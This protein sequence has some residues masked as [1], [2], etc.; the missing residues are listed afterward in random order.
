[1]KKRLVTALVAGI[2]AGGSILGLAACGE[3]NNSGKT[4]IKAATGARPAPFILT[5][6]NKDEALQTTKDGV[7]LTGY[8]IA[9]IT[10]V[11]KL[12]ELENYELDLNVSSNTLV[13]AQT[14][15]VDFAINNYGYNDD[16]AQ[17]YYYSY[18]YTKS[19]YQ[20][21]ALNVADSF[22]SV[23]N[24]GLKIYSGAG[25][26]TGN[27][28]ERWNE[29]RTSGQTKITL[30]YTSADMTVQLQEA[31]EGK[32]ALIHDEP[33]MYS[34]SKAYPDLFK[35][36][37][38]TTLSDEEVA[39]NITAYNTSHLLFGKAG[40]HAKEYRDLISGGIKKLYE[41]G[42]LAEFSKKYVGE[43]VNV[44]PSASDYTKYLN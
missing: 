34:Y 3:E 5:T 12:P 6:E 41:N 14:G 38:I 1:M 22:E 31:I 4:V 35:D 36:L 30:D 13:D 43:T 25:S 27:A 24:Q 18:P 21:A 11:F 8:D 39:Q 37:T 23:A 29:K 26:H 9:V 16:R 28:I 7:Y 32:V 17:S 15:T 2:L 42:K 19:R 20:F 10:E 44:V 40:A 33:V